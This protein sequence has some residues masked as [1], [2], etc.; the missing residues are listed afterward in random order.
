MGHH[1]GGD[2]VLWQEAAQQDPRGARGHREG[3][4]AGEPAA[5]REVQGVLRRHGGGVLEE[6]EE[7]LREEGAD[8]PQ[9]Q[10]QLERQAPA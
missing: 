2:G 9:A 7:A 1:A 8:F 5:G 3:D 6:E 4:V 10:A